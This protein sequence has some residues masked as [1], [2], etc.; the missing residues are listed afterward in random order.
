MGLS[1]A[2]VLS[3]LSTASV[4]DAALDPDVGVPS[5]TVQASTN[6]D[7]ADSPPG[8]TI[9]VGDAV[10][11]TYLV[12]NNGT[13]FL[14]QIELTD[15]Q[16]G[17]VICPGST[18]DPLDEMTCIANG[19]A[20]AGQ[21]ANVARVLGFW[22][23]EGQLA[24]VSDTDPSHY[25]GEEPL[26]IVGVDIEKATNG[27]D[28]DAAPGP[29]IT[30]GDTV[31]WTYMVT[32]TGET[33]LFNVTVTDDQGE[34]VSCPKTLL[35]LG[36]SMTCTAT[37]TAVVGQY[38]N[39]GTVTAD[40]TPAGGAP[41]PATDSDPSHYLGETAPPEPAAIDIEKATNGDDAD[42]A[43]GPTITV[44]ETVTWTYVVTNT[45]GFDLSDV[46][47]TDDQI[48][49][50]SCPQDTL[51]PSESMTCTAT[52]T[53]TVGQ[54]ENL[55]TAS[56]DWLSEGGPLPVTDSDPSH[57][58]GEQAPVPAIDIEKATNGE[59]ADSAPGPTITSGDPVTW[60]YLVTN[61]GETPLFGI[62]VFDDVEGTVTC[63][64][65]TLA[66]GESMTCTATGTA[67]AGQYANVGTVDA[68]S[69]SEGSLVQVSDS[70]PSHYY[71]EERRGG[72][73]CTPGY[74]KQPH[75]FFAWTGY[76]PGDSF[77]AVF[78]VPY[79]KTLLE[80]LQTGGGAEKALGR[81]AV[82]AL[83]NAASAGVSFDYSEGE[84]IAL[85]Q[86][87]WATGR[88]EVAKNM[89]AASNESG[90]DLGRGDTPPGKGDDKPGQ[91]KGRGDDP[92]GKGKGRLR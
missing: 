81:H 56:G 30:V 62:I 32:N 17:T 21:Y 37:G 66:V 87:A 19:T 70:D 46:T 82:G 8:P 4:A 80:A 65:T 43:P 61:S 63:P 3:V 38:E 79:D 47:V 15:D 50:I 84:V 44:G 57:Y 92:P 68:L 58:F 16:L 41:I 88:F 77:A 90:C 54:Y 69:G 64:Q 59:D 42:A 76:S 10:T 40:F 29:T 22:D 7:D 14:D 85:V 20:V 1:L 31:N 6:G 28:A 71:G 74:W 91:G 33:P 34:T 67:T 26:P 83:L 18:L 51:E 25:F 49:A 89:L 9:A 60:T 36:E 75:H 24:E 13:A 78:G 12:R 2:L 27:D 23:S 5:I 53:A 72:E 35:D 48:G 45:G 11:W 39:L 73:G 55:G 86:W 52:G